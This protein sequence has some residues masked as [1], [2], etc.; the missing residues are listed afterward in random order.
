MIRG[1][2]NL[3]N[4]KALDLNLSKLANVLLKVFVLILLAKI[5]QLLVRNQMLLCVLCSG[6]W[7][8]NTLLVPI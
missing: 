5:C 3:N 4:S 6:T 1:D 7:I 8:H 2:V